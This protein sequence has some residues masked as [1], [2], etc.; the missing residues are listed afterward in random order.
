M[1]EGEEMK[2]KVLSVSD[3]SFDG[4]DGRVTAA[5][6]RFTNDQGVAS[7]LSGYGPTMTGVL[8]WKAGD[9]H[10]IEPYTTTKGKPA[11]RLPGGGGGGR[12]GGGGFA[13][14][15][16]NTKEGQEYEQD[17]MHVRTAA[18]QAVAAGPSRA[19]GVASA[20]GGTLPVARFDTELA[21]TILAW[22][23]KNTAKS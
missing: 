5:K 19:N 21:D 9:E 18:M 17:N 16:R 2:I 3:D 20:G 12:G 1:E 10:E 13:A 8:A 4:K 22:L 6:L 11:F 23:R 7:E 15:W 14:A